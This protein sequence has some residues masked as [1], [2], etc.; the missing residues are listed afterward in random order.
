MNNVSKWAAQLAK[1]V[2]D[3]TAIPSLS[4]GSPE[5]DLETAYRVQR[6]LRAAAGP[7]AG[8]KLGVTSRA[9][10][11]QVGVSSPVYGYLAAA[12]AI[13]LGDSLDTAKLIQPRCE[14][15]IVF[16]LGRELAGPHVT[17]ADVLAACRGV[18]VGIEV[19]DSRYTDY[20]FTMADVVAD[21][22]SAGRY[23]VGTPV[24][25]QGIDL[26]LVGV[27]LEK[28]GKVSATASGAAVLG[29]PASAVAWLA[30][31]LWAEG[32]GLQAG[33]IVLSGGLTAAVPV[34]SGD[35]VVASIDRLGSVELGC[36]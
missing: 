8:S 20:R 24:D 15:E 30:R 11:A 31:Q 2:T 6:K 7:L 1:A 10:Q 29:H 27:V 14:P 17:T 28:N 12:D 4:A 33:E 23:V 13:D 32:E 21:N 5:L 18:A 35:V 25:P 9:K 22:T 3:R 26:R 34:V 36:R 19:L 16:I